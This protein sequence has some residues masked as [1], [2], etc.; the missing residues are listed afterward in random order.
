[1]VRG[2]RMCGS[3]RK[4]SRR[5]DAQK[6][7]SRARLIEHV[8]GCFDVILRRYEPRAGEMRYLLDPRDPWVDCDFEIFAYPAI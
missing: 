2:A 1:M 4:S 8:P 5:A 3:R 6:S 7:G